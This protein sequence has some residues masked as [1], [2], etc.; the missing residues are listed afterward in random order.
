MADLLTDLRDYLIAR[1]LVRKPSVAGAA[2]P[3][4]VEPREGVKAPNEGDSDTEKGDPVIGMF[5]TGGVPAKPF[6]SSLREPVIDFHFRASTAQ[7]AI[8][9]HRDL[10][11]ALIDQRQVQVGAQTVIDIEEW[12]ALSRLSSDEQGFTYVWAIWTQT[13]AL[14]TF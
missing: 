6:E 9:A 12:R 14:T 7:K 4:W 10:R 2:I 13:Y 3:L 1:G 5:L 8:R 11:A